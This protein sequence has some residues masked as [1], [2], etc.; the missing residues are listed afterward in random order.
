MDRLVETRLP[1]V[2]VGVQTAEVSGIGS[3]FASFCTSMVIYLFY[4]LDSNDYK[5]II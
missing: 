4:L 5:I 2:V 3:R 1:P